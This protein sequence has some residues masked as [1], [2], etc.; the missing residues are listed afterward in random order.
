M[1]IQIQHFNCPAV[2]YVNSIPL[3]LIPKESTR[4]T[5]HCYVHFFF[6][7][8]CRQKAFLIY[9]MGC[10]VPI[11]MASEQVIS[12]GDL[13]FCFPQVLYTELFHLFCI[14]V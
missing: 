8:K 9:A 2:I 13:W 4:A 1:S 10:M 7:L 5:V 11:F 14:P 3:L 6:Q 12:N